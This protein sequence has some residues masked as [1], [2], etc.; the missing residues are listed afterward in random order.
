MN[1]PKQDQMQAAAEKLSAPQDPEEIRAAVVARLLRISRSPRA[2]SAQSLQ[3]TPEAGQSRAAR[4]RR[5][6]RILLRK[7]KRPGAPSP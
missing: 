3:P 5:K 1:D 4:L 7:T 2:E 6:Q